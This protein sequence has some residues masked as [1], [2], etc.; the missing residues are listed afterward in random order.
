MCNITKKKRNE[1]QT[2]LCGGIS[3][4]EER[5]CSAVWWHGSWYFC[6]F[7]QMAA[8]WTDCGRGGCRLVVSFGLCVRM[9][10]STIISYTVPKQQAGIWLSRC[11]R[12]SLSTLNMLN[13][14]AEWLSLS[15]LDWY[16]GPAAIIVFIF[17]I[18]QI[19]MTN[20]CQPM[21]VLLLERGGA[22]IRRYHTLEW[23]WFL[24]ATMTEINT[25]AALDLLWSCLD[26]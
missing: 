26:S 21:G 24:P 18:Y 22:Y 3:Q 19:W 4:P 8:G 25:T 7:C 15:V 23:R 1:R 16:V 11:I 9:S 6:I 12:R 10:Q 20:V 2:V 13:R 5:S 17:F 14:N